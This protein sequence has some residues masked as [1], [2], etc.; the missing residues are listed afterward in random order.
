MHYV[1]RLLE[2]EFGTPYI[3]VNFFG[4]YNTAD[5]LRRIAQLT[6]NLT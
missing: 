2:E 1:A 6:A 3:D 5:S 4:A